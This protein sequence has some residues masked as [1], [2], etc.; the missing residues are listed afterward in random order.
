MAEDV[1]LPERVSY[2]EDELKS[3]KKQLLNLTEELMGTITIL[4]LPLPRGRRLELGFKQISKIPD[5]ILKLIVERY[6]IEAKN[7]D[8]SFDDMISPVV[9]VLGFERSWKILTIS[10]IRK[11]FGEW[12]V[13]KWEE[14]AKNHPCEE[15]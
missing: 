8:L 4:C 2:L 12:A 13:G 6:V 5:N 7:S 1:P 3:T 14:M 15:N 10:T 11:N 9:S